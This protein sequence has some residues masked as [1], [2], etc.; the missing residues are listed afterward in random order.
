MTQ[1]P[2]E[3][4]DNAT[5]G[6]E[7]MAKLHEQTGGM[8]G[9]APSAGNAQA[10][11]DAS[12]VGGMQNILSPYKGNVLAYICAGG[13]IGLCVGWLIAL[14]SDINGWGGV[15]AGA[16]AGAAIGLYVVETRRF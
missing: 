2:A 13:A 14:A 5:V 9:P 12:G 7:E 15:I 3:N 8:A 6:Q 16:I 4:V 11:D 10:T 1:E